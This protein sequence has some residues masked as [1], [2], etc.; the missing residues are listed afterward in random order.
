[1]QDLWRLWAVEMDVV[2]RSKKVSAKEA[3]TAA[4]ARL[5]AV[6]PKINAVVDHRPEDVLA[7]AAAVD[8]AIGRGEDAGP[9]GGVPVTVKV[10]I[11]QEGFATTNGLKLQRDAIAKSNNPVIDNLR[12]SGAVILGRTNCPAFSYRWFTTNLIHGDT[13]NPRDPGI[14]P[15][16]SSGGAGPAC[17][18]GT[19]PVAPAPAI[20]G[21]IRYPAYACGVH[22]LRP[23][24]GGV[25][26]F[27]AALPE[28][29]IGP[30]ITA[31]SGPLGRTI[32]DLRIALAAM[33]AP[34][35]RDP[36]W[37]PAPPAGPPSRK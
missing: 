29:G 23:T 22:G 15:G 3:A 6:N 12:K 17:R 14:T 33:S 13:K 7:Q 35:V 10:N 31:V 16:G 11:D 28:R 27:N 20:A 30:Q 19:G 34:D 26:A 21:S 32:G 1:M 8:A 36:W 2:R 4:L 18:A 25:A 24:I 9:L 37:V 5:D